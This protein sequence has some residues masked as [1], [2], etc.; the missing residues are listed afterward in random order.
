MAVKIRASPL[1][2]QPVCCSLTSEVV[3]TVSN[4]TQKVEVN[5]ETFTI[6]K[7]PLSRPATINC[8]TET[9]SLPLAGMHYFVWHSLFL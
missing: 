2:L 1:S 6:S 8:S 7:V 4:Y 9:L 5:L 3:K